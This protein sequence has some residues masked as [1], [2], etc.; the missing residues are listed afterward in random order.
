MAELDPVAKNSKMC[1]GDVKHARYMVKN[2][3]GRTDLGLDMHME[4]KSNQWFTA[5]GSIAGRSRFRRD[6]SI[7]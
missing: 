4:S 3:V 5:E 7:H 2:Y 6:H 1:D